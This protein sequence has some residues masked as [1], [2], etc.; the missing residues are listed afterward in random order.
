MMILFVIFK[1]TS[2]L[3][4]LSQ[5]PDEMFNLAWNVLFGALVRKEPVLQNKKKVMSKHFCVS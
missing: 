3:I 1:N 5:P 4:L 2:S